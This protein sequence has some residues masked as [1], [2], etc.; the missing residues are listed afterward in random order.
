MY[1]EELAWAKTHMCERM[2]Q[3]ACQTCGPPCKFDMLGLEE[4]DQKTRVLGTRMGG[5]R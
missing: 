5:K 1:W 2:T 4:L 3:Q